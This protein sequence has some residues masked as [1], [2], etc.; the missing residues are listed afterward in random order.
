MM[1]SFDFKSETFRAD[2]EL[3][4]RMEVAESI[5]EGDVS[6]YK[7]KHTREDSNQDSGRK[8]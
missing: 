3:F 4:K 1:L 8:K 6:P 2:I 7:N 5:Y